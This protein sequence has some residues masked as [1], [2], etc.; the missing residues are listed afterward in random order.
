MKRNDQPARP[1]ARDLGVPFDGEPGA[2]NAIT[3]VPGVLVGHTTLVRGSGAQVIGQGPVRTGVTAILPHAEITRRPVLGSYF[4]FN[5]CGEMI[6]TIYLEETGLL[7]SPI[8]LTNTNSVGTVRDA[9]IAWG[10][11]TLPVVAETWDGQLN[12]IY[13]F[14]VQRE[15]VFAA[16]EGATSGPV[17]EGNV[18]GGTGMTAYDFKAGIGTASRRVTIGEEPYTLGVL[19][20]ANHGERAQLLVAGVPVG[21]E[22]ADHMPVIHER[23]HWERQGSIIIVLGTDAPL[24]PT[25]LKAVAKRAA[26]GL[27]RTGSIG[28]YSSGDIFIAFSTAPLQQ[29]RP[30]YLQLRM[31]DYRHI[32]PV[33][34]A[35]VQATDEAIINALVAAETMTGINDNTFYALPHARLRQVL[36]KYRRLATAGRAARPPTKAQW[37]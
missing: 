19:V 32:N 3:D 22:I 29:E 6:G 23:N 28:G 14:H 33:F 15:H 2:F 10:G 25:Q 13:G 27:A 21:R 8:M 37:E 12:D 24:L 18:G 11:S 4:S 31:L 34:A 16:L 7:H 20:Q 17:A 36:R 1:R 30:G 26:L 9:V 5:G 35:A